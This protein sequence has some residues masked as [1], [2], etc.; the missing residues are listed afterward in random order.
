MRTTAHMSLSSLKTA[1]HCLK[2][3]YRTE[4]CS[5]SAYANSQ[6]S[7]NYRKQQSMYDVR[8]TML[9]NV[10][11]YLHQ[12]LHIYLKPTRS[13]TNAMEVVAAISPLSQSKAPKKLSNRFYTLLTF[14]FKS[15]RVM[16]LLRY[17]LWLYLFNSS[18]DVFAL[19]FSIPLFNFYW[20]GKTNMCRVNCVPFMFVQAVFA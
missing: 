18:I 6:H 7:R 3:N 1:G 13:N 2:L 10:D 8:A 9:S 15:T 4:K 5:R 19:L 11:I 12:R 16:Y 17:T 14:D 20:I